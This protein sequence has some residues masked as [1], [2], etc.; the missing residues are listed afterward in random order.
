M[1]RGVDGLSSPKP[2]RHKQPGRPSRDPSVSARFDA[3]PI[4]L[5]R[6]VEPVA[7]LR[8]T[9]PLR[10]GERILFAG[11]LPPPGPTIRASVAHLDGPARAR[12]VG[13][14]RHVTAT[15]AA[16]PSVPPPPHQPPHD[17]M[18]SNVCTNRYPPGYAI[19]LDANWVSPCLFSLGELVTT[20]CHL[21]Q[22]RP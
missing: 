17:R 10:L 18:L 1:P 21:R 2:L 7:S 3:R 6:D 22:P 15:K 4:A 14:D 12:V 11:D 13:P 16:V 8:L 5:G 19:D 9:T 20:C